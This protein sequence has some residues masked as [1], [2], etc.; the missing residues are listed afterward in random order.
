MQHIH[1]IAVCGIGMGSLAGLLKTSGYKVTGSDQNV[2]PP[3]SNQLAD[4]GIPIALGYGAQNLEPRPD[5]VIIGNAAKE[6]NP[7]VMAVMEMGIPYISFPQALAQF[8]IKDRESL[9]MCGT[10]GKTTSTSML[11][12]ILESAGLSPSMMVGGVA[13]NFSKS[14]QV[15]EGRH[16]VLEGDEYHTAFF[17]RV[18]KFHHYRP[19]MACLNSLEFDHGDIYRD[20]AH[21]QESFRE[22]L[23][24]RMPEDGFLAVCT[25]YPAVKPLLGAIKCDCE[26]Y[27]L[28]GSPHWQASEIEISEEGT[29][30]TVLQGGEIYGRFFMQMS[31]RHNV[32]NALGVIAL[33]HR[34]GLSVPAIACGLA[35]FEGVKR[36][37]E[38]RGIVDDVVVIDDFA[39]HPTAVRETVRAIK[40]RYPKRNVWAVVEP[41]TA[42]SRRD[43]FQK[44]YVKSFDSADRVIVADV[45]MPEMIEPERIFSPARL[46]ADLVANGHRAW[47]LPTANAIVEML[48][49]DARPGDVVLV[50]SNGAFDGIHEKLL[51][52]FA[53]RHPEGQRAEEGLPA[54]APARQVPTEAI[55][56]QDIAEYRTRMIPL[57]PQPAV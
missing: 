50:M 4:L 37:Q 45:F 16:F 11:A 49:K 24:E 39:H 46:V 31:G 41:R 52:A 14:F 25:D 51:K 27:G 23:I 55:R 5:L 34:V 42:S 20:L 7:E 17:N 48:R 15:G 18:P 22:H 1:M 38:I 33:C 47:H 35:T 10:H 30:F 54:T 56:L 3:M 36:R 8:F 53:E 57:R 6:K 40:S 21:I 2:Y 43:F 26:T 44:D 32:Q 9:V 28:K 12:W 19:R 29:T 13:K